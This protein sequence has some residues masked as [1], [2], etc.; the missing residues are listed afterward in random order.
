MMI[1]G[2]QDESTSHGMMI[3]IRFWFSVSTFL[4]KIRKLM[5]KGSSP[6]V[7]TKNWDV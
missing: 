7:L 1:M 4:L 5:R 6:V 3:L 2:K